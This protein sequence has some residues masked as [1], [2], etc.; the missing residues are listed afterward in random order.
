[1]KP[2]VTQTIPMAIYTAFNGVGAS[3]QVAMALSVL[4]I[5]TALIVLLFFPAARGASSVLGQD[6]TDRQT[7]VAEVVGPHPVEGSHPSVQTPPGLPITLDCTVT[8]GPFTL[9]VDLDIDGGAVVGVVGPN[10]AGK[11]TLINLVAGHI[12][13]ATGAVM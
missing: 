12:Q 6:A 2:G 3:R 11:S 5:V 8:R 1:N 9:E 10:A 7:T 13:P 4:L